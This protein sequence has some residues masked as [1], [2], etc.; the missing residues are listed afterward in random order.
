MSRLDLIKSQREQRKKRVR[1]IVGGTDDRPR[2]A[3][4]ISNRHITAQIINDEQMK[5]L[6]YSSTVGMK[7]SGQTMTEQAATIGKDIAAKAKKA[8][9]SKVVFDRGSRLYHGRIKALADAA[10]EGGLEF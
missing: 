3:V 7:T 5:T 8:K 4:S 2:L 1:A 9:V 6:A 10:R